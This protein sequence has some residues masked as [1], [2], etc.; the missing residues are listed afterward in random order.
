MFEIIVFAIVVYILVQLGRAKKPTESPPSYT[1]NQQWVDYIAA[2][3]KLAKNKTEKAVLTRMLADLHQQGMPEPTI[4]LVSTNTSEAEGTVT[5]DVRLDSAS[6]HVDITSS[7]T[8]LSSMATNAASPET[9]QA[10]ET[11][12]VVRQEPTLDNTTLLLYF[13]AFLFLASAGLFVALTGAYGQIRVATILVVMAALYWGGLWLY[14][15]K[16]KLRTAGYTFI[17]M[18]MMLAPLAGLALYAYVMKDQPQLVWL[19]TSGMCLALY[20]HA[21]KKIQTTFMEYICIGTFVSLFESA[22]SVLSLPVYYYGWGFAVV[23]LLLQARST[24]Q[25]KQDTFAAPSALSADVLMPMSVFAALYMIPA[26]GMIQLSISLLLAALYYALQAW[27]AVVGSAERVNYA[28]VTHI[29]LLMS[30]TSFAYGARQKL[31]D[32]GIALLVIAVFEL[33]AILVRKTSAF[34]NAFANATFISLLFAAGCSWLNPWLS[35]VALSSAILCGVVTWLRYNRVDMYGA[36]S[37]LSLGLPFLIGLHALSIDWN[38]QQLMAAV[39]GLAVVHIGM[40]F[41]VRNG[42]YDS[43]DWRNHWRMVLLTTLVLGFILALLAGAYNLVVSAIVIAF[44]CYAVARYDSE[45]SLWVNASSVFSWL[46]IVF[47]TH[48]PVLWLVAVIVGFTWNLFL[49][50]ANRLELARWLGSVAWLLLPVGIARVAPSLQEAGWYAGSYLWV[51]VGLVVARAVAQKR[52]ADLPLAL[53]ELERRLHSDSQA[54]VVGYSLAAMIAGAASFF[55]DWRVMPAIIC[56]VLAVLFSVVARRIERAPDIIVV[57]PSLLQLGLWGTYE[58]G[59]SVGW[60]VF[61]SL[62]VAASTYLYSWIR[63][64]EHDRNRYLQQLR[65]AS[66]ALMYAAPAFVLVLKTTWVMPV[67]LAVAAAATLHFVWGRQQSEREMAG[68][69]GIFAL[70]WLLS[71]HGIDNIQVYAH[72]LAALFG[73]YAFWRYKKQDSEGGHQYLVAMLYTATIPLGLQ[74]I[75]GSVGG[76][77]GWWFLGEQICIMLLGMFIQNRFVTRWGM[78]VA[79]G[80]VLYQLRALAWLSLT[81]LA[82]FLIGLAVY[83]L[84]KTDKKD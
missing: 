61:A 70:F 5:Q 27:Q 71:Y 19:L 9:L 81:L 59:Q 16:P 47:A 45:A 57:V 74:V 2:Y 41:V 51:T 15:S 84:Q 28:L 69:I 26:H 68:G 17:G 38:A 13:G 56:A 25:G 77:Y 24:K 30:A 22:I 34:M 48:R 31:T 8:G 64:G 53:S 18:G 23:A 79:V 10:A 49:V 65:V 72:I 1:V 44:A 4:A 32:I 37:A 55:T 46:P 3:R 75:G 33:A 78:Y 52:I 6:K 36:A 14:R 11:H 73:L 63:L 83:R 42:T 21:Y 12:T 43:S 50:F 7:V 54:Y 58:A 80:S 62:C 76:L 35:V 66:L 20:L 60:Y 40:L 29:A 67:S 39:F 82:V